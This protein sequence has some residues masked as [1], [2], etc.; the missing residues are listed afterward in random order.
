MRHKFILL[1]ACLL[2]FFFFVDCCDTKDDGITNPPPEE[3]PEPE[4]I[5]PCTSTVIHYPSPINSDPD[6]IIE[7]NDVTIGWI[8]RLP[9]IEYVW[10]SSH[11][12]IEGWPSPGQEVT[13]KAYIKNWSDSLKNDIKYQWLLDGVMVDSGRID[14]LPRVYS[15]V[16]YR[17]NWT[18]NR[19][20]LTFWADTDN[21]IS[22]KLTI[23]TDAISLGLYVEQ[24]FY[25]YFHENQHKLGIGSNSFEGWAQ[26]QIRFYNELF[27]RAIF[28]ET[29]NG[30]LDRIRI[31]QI[32]IVADGALPLVQPAGNT[33]FDPR[34]AIPNLNDRTVDLQWGFPSEFV[35]IGPYSNHTWVNFDNQFYYS[36]FLQH[37][38]GHARYLIDAYGFDLAHGLSLV[39]I[40]ENGQLIAGTKYLPG[41]TIV[42]NGIEVLKL[43]QTVEKGLM[44]AQWRWM[45]RY[46][47]ITMNLIEGQRATLGN[48]NGAENEG[49]F[50]NDLPGENRFRIK[51]KDGKFLK[52]AQIHIF[53]SSMNSQTI[54]AA[55]PKYFDDVPDLVLQ[56]DENAQVLLGQNPFSNVGQVKHEWKVFSNVIFI[57]RIEYESAVGYKIVE[58]SRFNIE[59]WRGNTEL[60]DYEV[61]VTLF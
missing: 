21:G 24:S 42:V 38:L 34:Q 57:M 31:D 52:N 5:E 47:A 56:T 32:T 18:F 43:H 50:L 16:D 48:Y 7:L 9:T 23:N 20:E 61:C 37:E 40:K 29:P 36:G 8:S 2:C 45:D 60:A 10:G 3:E 19:H 54:G 28:D 17:W 1:C 39:D 41:E 35:Q 33:A 25:D 11:P 14:L 26:R 27:K 22:N 49:I 53:Q 6:P 55:Y 51:D 44:N 59:Y 30:V 12:Q 4:I 15:T 13:W 58:A 46:G